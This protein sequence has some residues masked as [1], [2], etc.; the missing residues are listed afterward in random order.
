M[1]TL[2]T[3]VAVHARQAPGAVWVLVMGLLCSQAAAADPLA[4]NDRLQFA[5]GLYARGMYAFAIREYQSFL[6]TPGVTEGLDTAHFRMGE[7]YREI[8]KLIE[9]EQAYRK[10]F[11]EFPESAFRMHA[12]FKR[13]D[14]FMQLKR[15]DDAIGLYD[16]VLG[17]KPPSEVAAASLYFQGL[18]YLKS[19]KPDKAGANFGMLRSQH[20][21]TRYHAYALLELGQLHAQAA[22]ADVAAGGKADKDVEQAV[23]FFKTVADRPPTDRIG[24]EALFQVAELHFRTRN[25]AASAEAYRNLLGKYPNDSRTTEARLQA[26]WSAHNAGLY[27]EARAQADGA[28]KAE[29]DPPDEWLYLLANSQRHLVQNDVA[30]QTYDRLLGQ[31]AE[32]RYAEASR[33]EKALCFYKMGRFKDAA[34]E[35]RKVILSEK[36]KK[37]VCWLLA[38]SFAALNDSDG[39]IQ[40]YQL[41]YREFPDSSVACDATY[42]LAHHL[43]LRKEYQQAA[44]FYDAVAQRFP[45]RDLAPKAL[46][47]AAYCLVQ[48]N[49]H[50]EAAR[51]WATLIQKYPKHELVEESLYQKAMSEVRLKRDKDAM[52]SLHELQRRFP[53]SGFMPESHYWLGMLLKGTG[54]LEDAATSLRASLKGG[55]KQELKR[56]AEFHLAGVLQKQGKDEEASVL[57]QTLVDSPL[58]DKF[59]APLLEWLSAYHFDKQRYSQ[60]A[61]AARLLV[62]SNT[63]PEWQQI[64]WCLLGRAENSQGHADAAQDAFTRALKVQAATS[65]AGEAALRLGELKLTAKDLPSAKVYFERAAALSS[66][67]ALLGVKARA[68]AGLGRTARALKDD[69]EAARYFMSVAILYDDPALVSECLAE[70][71]QAFARLGRDE[72]R[73]MAMQE[74]RE[75]YPDSPHAK[76]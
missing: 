21:S 6:D 49:M 50:A 24:A 11:G 27:V 4:T 72:D 5:N 15:Y 10:V 30:V 14:I 61:D 59:S 76:P 28:V 52:A 60:A 42:R 68:Y 13:A 20:K 64:G 69:E 40:Y 67:D 35:A 17:M 62:N 22:A 66:G 44:Q 32:S 19:G 51:D 33:Y 38:E 3:N 57:F 36:L 65:F 29:L 71:G 8:G 2:R 63:E 34:D 1:T 46:F 9:A 70:A 47:A 37:D 53:G 7:C 23:A 56:K 16:V 18:A 26:A 74:L 39:A 25:F 12:G 31:F 45:E 55:P 75:R 54:K 73:K 48:G 43:Q 58:K 41:L